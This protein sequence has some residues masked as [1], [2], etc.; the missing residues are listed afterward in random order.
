MKKLTKSGFAGIAT[1]ALLAVVG[2]APSAN[3][4][5]NINFGSY[6]IT[7]DGY[8]SDNFS[9]TLAGSADG[10][11]ATTGGPLEDTWGIFQIQLIKDG[12]STTKFTDNNGTTEYWGVIYNSWDTAIDDIGGGDFKYHSKG[13]TIDVYKEAG[14]GINDPIWQTVYNQGTAGRIGQPISG[15][16]G[17]TDAVGATKVFS[18]TMNGEMISFAHPLIN[19]SFST[20]ASGVLTST[21]NTLFT[22]P[23]NFTSNSLSFNLASLPTT[24]PADWDIHFAGPIDGAVVP[25]PEPSTYGLIS[26]GALLGLVAYRRMKVR[27][28][29]V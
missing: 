15:Y 7:A 6:T 21:F 9:G 25:V 26:A 24:V 16:H 1:A 22:F 10:A 20:S 19:G 4:Q 17:I 12:P 13:L 29:A 27:A 14:E 2:F 5:I 3:A 11:R 28:Q 8:T 18:A 23:P